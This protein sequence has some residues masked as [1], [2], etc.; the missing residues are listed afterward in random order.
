MQSN[1]REVTASVRRDL[2]ERQT[3][4]PGTKAA[5]DAICDEMFEAIAVALLQAP[6]I[7]RLSDFDRLK[8][9]FQLGAECGVETGKAIAETLEMKR[10]ASLTRAQ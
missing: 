10:I 1:L 9:A 3:V 7:L 5:V 8:I 6:P 2:V 4:S